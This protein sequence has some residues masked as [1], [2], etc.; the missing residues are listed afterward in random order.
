MPP[1]PQGMPPGFAPPPGFPGKYKKYCSAAL[2]SPTDFLQ[3]YAS[4]YAA[5]STKPSSWIPAP[6]PTCRLSAWWYGIPS[7]RHGT[8]WYGWSTW[9]ALPR[10]TLE[11]YHDEKKV[12]HK[13]TLQAIWMSTMP[14]CKPLKRDSSSVTPKIRFIATETHTGRSLGDEATSSTN[15]WEIERDVED[16]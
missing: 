3:R 8:S 9:Y 1:L 15:G 16:I 2:S 4:R 10:K 7:S 13:E 11:A 6:R 14:P 5:S 12:L